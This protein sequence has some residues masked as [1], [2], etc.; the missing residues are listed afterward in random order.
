[1]VQVYDEQVER[2]GVRRG[3]DGGMDHSGVFLN[4]SLQ[5]HIRHILHQHDISLSEVFH[6]AIERDIHPVL[7]NRRDSRCDQSWYHGSHLVLRID[8]YSVEGHGR[9]ELGR[10]HDQV[11]PWRGQKRQQ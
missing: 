6:L 2:S 4:S 9:D 10:A 8:N 3:H 5:P 1:M 11:Q 7:R